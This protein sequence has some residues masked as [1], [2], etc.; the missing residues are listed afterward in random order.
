MSLAKVIDVLLDN[1]LILY[2]AG[3]KI[4][5]GIYDLTHPEPEMD[6][7]YEEEETPEPDPGRE[8]DFDNDGW[9]PN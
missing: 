2:R 6:E 3:F 5:E 7:D 4:G 9:S 1:S 8:G